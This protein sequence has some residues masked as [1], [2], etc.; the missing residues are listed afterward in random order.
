M[1]IIDDRWEEAWEY[2]RIKDK[3][4]DKRLQEMRGKRQAEDKTATDSV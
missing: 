2:R 3:R 4:A 1:E